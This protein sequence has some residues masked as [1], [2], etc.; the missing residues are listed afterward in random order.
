[1]RRWSRAL[2]A[3]RRAEV[4]MLAAE[5]ACSAPGLAMH[6]VSAREEAFGDRIV[7]F[8]RAL[9]RLLAVPAPDVAALAAKIGFAADHE[10][11]TLNGCQQCLQALKGDAI[12]L[13]GQKGRT[14]LSYAPLRVRQAQDE[15]GLMGALPHFAAG[16]I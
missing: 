2:L 15:R 12:R 16:T 3:V 10:A 8:N 4:A 14:A 9:A 13:V 7:G 5:A 6:E 11:V 1:L